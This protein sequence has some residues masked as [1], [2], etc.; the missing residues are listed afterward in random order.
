MILLIT[1]VVIGLVIVILSLKDGS[2]D[3]LPQTII[4]ASFFLAL[5]LLGPLIL[6][7]TIPTE[8]IPHEEKELRLV[9]DQISTESRFF[10]FGGRLDGKPGYTY[11]VEQDNGGFKLESVE[12][13]NV[14]VFE[15]DRNDAV[16]IILKPQPRNDFFK[17]LV[18]YGHNDRRY[19]F[20]VPIGTIANKLELDG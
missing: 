17:R 7:D 6:A 18:F 14:T 4:G 1:C 12:A 13:E 15:E 20:H 5:G 3:I 9:H 10:L 16:L 19:E 8:Y 11:Y 2:D